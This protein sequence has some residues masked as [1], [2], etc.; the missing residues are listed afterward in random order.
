M[1]SASDRVTPGSG[2]QWLRRFVLVALLLATAVL[3]A[4]PEAV[5]ASPCCGITRI[6]VK[7]Q[8]VTAKEN[9]TG[10]TFTFKVSD[11]KLLN[12][13]RVGQGVY[14]NFGTKQVS[15]DGKAS[16]CS[17]VSVSVTPAAQI[18]SNA[19]PGTPCCNITSIDLNASAVTARETATGKTFQFK[20]GN[21]ALLKSLNIGQGVYANFATQQVSVD[22]ISPCCNIVGLVPAAGATS[23]AAPVVAAKAAGQVNPATPCC[24]ITGIDSQT[25][26]VAAKENA[27]GHTFAFKVNDS[28]LL[29]SLKVGQGI[30]ANFAAKQV[31]V[32]N[33]SPC[34]GIVSQLSAVGGTGVAAP[35]AAA[36]AAGQANPITPC[37]GITGV[38]A[39]TGIIAARE[40]ATGR[41]FSFKVTDAN[42]LKSLKS[43]QGVYANFATNQVSV[44]NVT[45]CC[46][47]LSQAQPASAT[48][49][50][51]P[52]AT[53]AA[54][55]VNPVAPC[56][57]I[58]AINLL[59]GVVEA[60]ENATG[61]TFS[62]KLNDSNLL[63]SLKV[64]QGIYA[65][66]AAK[67]VSVDNLSP[68]CSIVNGPTASI[69]PTPQSG[70]APSSGSSSTGGSGSKDS[71][72]SSKVQTQSKSSKDL[73]T[74]NTE[75]KATEATTEQAI[76][77]A[78]AENPPPAGDTGPGKPAPVLAG[79]T[80]TEAP[81]TRPVPTLPVFSREPLQVRI[82]TKNKKWTL[83]TFTGVI[84]GRQVKEEAFYHLV[85][86][87]G[88][89]ES[90]LPTSIKNELLK[91]AAGSRGND[92]VY[93]VHKSSA[94]KIGALLAGKGSGSAPPPSNSVNPTGSSDNGCHD[95]FGWGNH[96]T[97]T[98][99]INF[100]TPGD[101]LMLTL[102]DQNLGPVN[103]SGQLNIKAPA[104]GHVVGEIELG[105][106]DFACEP[107]A[108]K[109]RHLRLYGTMDLG[110]SL[111]LDAHLG[112]DH[113]FKKR[114]YSAPLGGFGF[115]I[116][117]IPVYIGFDAF[118]EGRIDVKAPDLV[119]V[120]YSAQGT[121]HGT[122]DATC[123]MNGCNATSSGS[124][125]WS[126]SGDLTLLANGVHAI[127]KPGVL[128]G[129]EG[130]LYEADI[131]N[132]HVGVEP[133]AKGDLWAYSGTGC[134]KGAASPA[135]DYTKAL[136][137]DVDGGF[138]I[139]AGIDASGLAP[140]GFF[141]GVL[142]QEFVLYN[143][144]KHL[145]FYDLIGSTALTPLVETNSPA[146]ASQPK[147]VA[148]QMRSCYPYAKDKD[149]HPVVMTYEVGWGDTSANSLP[150]AAV[151]S[152]VN[153][154]HIW[155]AAGQFTIQARPLRDSHGRE[156]PA[157]ITQATMQV[158]AATGANPLGQSKG[159]GT[160]TA[161]PLIVPNLIGQ[162]L[163]TIAANLV[164]STNP[165]HLPDLVPAITSNIASCS[166]SPDQSCQQQ[167]PPYTAT[168]PLGVKNIAP[169]GVSGPIYVTL[170]DTAG[171]TL[172]SW[173]V[174]GLDSNGQAYPG[175]F[176]YPAQF[177]CPT[178]GTNTVSVGAAPAPNY[179]LLV[180]PPSGVVEFQ[181]NNNSAQI[182]IP[183]D[184]TIGP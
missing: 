37:C 122:L 102:N 148:V 29:E 131:V 113:R 13:L 125:A 61:R 164:A 178:P 104:S 70:P 33:L 109:L 141:S 26:I 69:P 44:D 12:S 58:T 99:S 111:D 9:G 96:M 52:V 19:R 63:K 107:V 140:N 97:K 145:K 176:S 154:S 28:T 101:L 23:I 121:G 112:A 57:G 105:I 118:L 60:K 172:R 80:Q 71:G 135:R 22:G 59:T 47:I 91:D 5:A 126:T 7:S 137:A 124:F 133:Y 151:G 10:R 54:G 127:V 173:T 45:P 4:A 153:P 67:Q 6:D 181:T 55:Q 110:A 50:A 75:L 84:G 119:Q 82:I 40:N 8:L 115:F 35:V 136:T 177:S 17:M 165:N 86:A 74:G 120:K 24:S 30:Y 130:Y 73:G 88:I 161:Q 43:G 116:G 46:S 79:A 20:V 68:C 138:D 3:A 27:T 11:V 150:Q 16:C 36:R 2:G 94:E 42:L 78:T 62:F 163:Q 32:D 166:Y 179:V 85:G 123:T 81:K 103:A 175:S 117:V 132:A 157:Q 108:L 31:S 34:C 18:G 95:M 184:A 180:A 56:C 87:E 139:V 159:G 156:L 147:T 182:Y 100:S 83:Q 167:C 90:P 49:A 168:I 72:K 183:A 39:E 143:W 48:G 169:Y 93:I 146:N 142:D 41:T 174:N 162:N 51:T 76:R 64:G 66:F 21:S 14:A 77:G 114:L 170:Q 128:G 53:K 15:I 38:N 134:S 65:N 106:L 155:N 152:A 98:A 149:G 158:N 1:N 144:E 89:S 129:V 92:V 25:G 171:H 160:L